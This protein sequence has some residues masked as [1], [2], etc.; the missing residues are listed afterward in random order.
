MLLIGM[1]D[2]PYVR[3]CAVSMKLMGVAFEHRPVSVF[4]QMDE[5]RKVNPVVKAPTLVAGDGTMLMDSTL[6]LDHVEST[7]PGSRRLTP[8]DTAAR[9]AL[10]HALGFA[11]AATDKGVS[12]VYEH[13][14]RP[15]EKVHAPWLDR[16]IE[17]ANTACAELEKI[18]AKARPW[19]AGDR[20]G[21]ADVMAACG[22]RFN[23]SRNAGDIP[24]ARYP[25]LAALCARAEAL[26][27][28]SSTLPSE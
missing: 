6:I 7:L 11:L 26:A 28:F 22:W 24:A 8:V 17:Q 16:V 21:A 19:I 25:A 15:P 1:L 4:R 23:Q 14:R 20:I 18:A 3:R 9:L 13:E 27:E 2:S 5:F 12:I 10:L